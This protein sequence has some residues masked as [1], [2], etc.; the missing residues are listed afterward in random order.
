ME[1]NVQTFL[2]VSCFMNRN[3]AKNLGMYAW[4]ERGKGKK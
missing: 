4:H 3:I 2:F 1:Q